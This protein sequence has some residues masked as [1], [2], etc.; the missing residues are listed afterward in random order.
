[1]SGTEDNEKQLS[2]EELL[3]SYGPGSKEAL[4]VGSKL[5]GKIISI[6]KESVFVDTGSKVDG[7]VD[8]AELVDE[9]GDLP[10]QVGDTLDLYIMS[11]RPGE[12]RL[13][14]ALAGV[15]GAEQLKDAYHQGIPIEGRVTDTCKG[16]FNVEVI[17]HRA[18]CPISQIDTIY[19][20]HPEEYVGKTFRFLITELGEGGKNIVVSRRTLL[21]Q[22]EEEARQAFLGSLKPGDICTG[23]VS[24]IMPYGAFVELSPGVEG[25]VHISEMSWSRLGT[26]EEILHTGDAITVKIIGIEKNASGGNGKISLSMK[27]AGEDPWNTV[28][29]KY[30]PGQKLAGKVTRCMDYGV[31]V[32]IE[33]GVEG[34]VHISEMSYTKRVSRTRDEVAPGD[35]VD[36]MIKEID[37]VNRRISLS[38]KDAEGDPWIGIEGRYRTGQRVEGVIEKKEKFGL[39][40]NLE[41][42]VTGLLPKSRISRFHDPSSIERK[43]PGEHIT[44]VIEAIDTTARKLTLA[45]GDSSDEDDWQRFSGSSGQPV[46]SLGEKLQQALKKKK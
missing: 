3:D 29:R 34:L 31:F 26:P 30:S 28:E 10:Y 23:R 45:P 37:P 1:M 14:R 39:F 33:P 18:F 8:L 46:S 2:M 21:E 11:M 24:R 19:V 22:E 43:Q 35:V 32:E 27:Q 40:I 42:G 13:S 9:N 41:P 5:S 16:G 38:M 44:V 6:G 7:V 15:G 12:I 36:I 4:R 20:E 25:M 17:K